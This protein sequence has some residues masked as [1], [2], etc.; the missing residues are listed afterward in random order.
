MNARSPSFELRQFH[1]GLVF[2]RTS[3]ARQQEGESWNF[4]P[5]SMA[6]LWRDQGSGMRLAIYLRQSTAGSPKGLTRAI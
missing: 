2:S 5:L 3:V 6:R 4:A 1:A